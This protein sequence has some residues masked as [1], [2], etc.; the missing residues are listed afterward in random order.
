MSQNAMTSHIIVAAALLIWYPS[1]VKPTL[2]TLVAHPLMKL[3]IGLSSQDL[4]FLVVFYCVFS[5]P[6]ASSE[7][8]TLYK[9]LSL[10]DEDEDELVREMS[11]ES[12]LDGKEDVEKC[13][14][15]K[16]LSGKN[17]NID[18]FKG[19]IEQIWS[20]F[21]QVEVE[22]SKPLKR[23]LRLKPG[24]SDEIFTVGL[25]YEKLPDFCFACGRI[26]HGIKDCEDEVARKAALEGSKSM[27]ASCDTTGDGSVSKHPD[28]HVSQKVETASRAAAEKITTKGVPLVNLNAEEEGGPQITDV[29]CVDRLVPG[30]IRP[31]QDT[32]QPNSDSLPSSSNAIVVIHS[33]G[34]NLLNEVVR[35]NLDFQDSYHIPQEKS[36][37][38]GTPKLS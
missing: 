35:S 4:V 18:A 32:T 23:W 31:L 27:G 6:M 9:N 7:I 19:L 26:G 38:T 24:S 17:V 25:K 12:S 20:P 14:V 3:I 15:G 8:E 13:L 5:G 22:S 11:E 30:F 29:I 2:A 10:E 21:G 28:S 16:V 37:N 34:P 33:S 1:L 36:E